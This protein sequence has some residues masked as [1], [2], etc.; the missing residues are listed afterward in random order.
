MVKV[1]NSYVES[2]KK[3]SFG[4]IIQRNT[5]DHGDK[6]SFWSQV[7]LFTSETTLH[8]PTHITADDRHP[9]E[10]HNKI[11]NFFKL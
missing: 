11:S 6:I 9:I 4:K 2:S 5:H 3:G 10:R 8:G 1:E 7:K